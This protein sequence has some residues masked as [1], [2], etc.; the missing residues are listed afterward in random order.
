MRA[1]LLPSC[2]TPLWPHGLLL[3]RLF[4]PWDSPGKR[5]GVGC[6]FL[7]Q[8]I[9]P[10][11]GSNLCLLCLLPCRQILYPPSH[12]RTKITFHFWS[13]S[14]FYLILLHVWKLQSRRSQFPPLSTLLFFPLFWLSKNRDWPHVLGSQVLT[15]NAHLKI[16]IQMG[17]SH[18]SL[19]FHI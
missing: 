11:Q 7:L 14:S 12:T 4:C 8:G 19:Y 18:F 6:H 5:T 1:K 9:F 10:S 2:P 3:A 17:M 16:R 15:I 13:L